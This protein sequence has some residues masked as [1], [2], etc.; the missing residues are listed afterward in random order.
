[1]LVNDLPHLPVDAKI[2]SVKAEPA[3]LKV[4]K[5][6]AGKTIRMP[7]TQVNN[8]KSEPF[9]VVLENAIDDGQTFQSDTTVDAK[10]VFEI[11]ALPVLGQ[12]FKDLGVTIESKKEKIESPFTLEYLAGSIPIWLPVL[13]V[14][15]AVLGVLIAG[16]LTRKAFPRG[17]AVEIYGPD[18]NL[19]VDAELHE[20]DL[21][22]FKRAG[23]VLG[24]QGDLV[25]G[26]DNYLEVLADGPKNPWIARPLQENMTLN[27]KPF[28][29]W[30]Q[31]KIGDEIVSKQD[32]VVIKFVPV[33]EQ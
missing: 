11:E 15:A 26:K 5:T 7:T 18:G 31:L 10:L 12:G 30:E 24:D 17:V 23:F 32:R 1:M 19:I 2:L 14:I 16:I 27:G 25:A 22:L 3:G 8:G 21:G 20:Y 13:I 6:P 4:I 29:G 28:E 33:G 9:E